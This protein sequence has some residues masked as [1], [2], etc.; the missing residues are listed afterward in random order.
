MSILAIHPGSYYHIE[1]LESAK[2]GHYFDKLIRPEELDTLNLSDFN[3]LLVPCRTPANRMIPHKQLLLDYLNQGGVI[4]ATGESHSELWLPEVEFTPQD[5][6]YWWWLEKNGDL[7]VRQ[8]NPGNNFFNYLDEKS[9][10]WHLH[11]WFDAPDG[12]EIL[13]VNAERKPILY[14]DN[15]TT[16][17]TMVITSLDPFYHHGSHFMPATTKFLDGFLP[18]MKATYDVK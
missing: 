10:T 4:V 8:V 14:I 1:S 3:I 9:L 13:A 18:W 17:G 6:N 15:I 5:T 12:V 11:G 7:G 2:Y 16:K